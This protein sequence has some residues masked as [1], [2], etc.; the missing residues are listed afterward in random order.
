M[1]VGYY[2]TAPQSACHKGY[3][4]IIQL[5]LDHKAN[6][7]VKG[8]DYGIALVAASC[9][10]QAMKVELLLFKG[11]ADIHAINDCGQTAVHCASWSGNRDVIEQLSSRGANIDTLS[12]DGTACI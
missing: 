9:Q 1:Q 7:N 12:K 2:H 8:G 6:V 5:L 3:R 11:G 10:D 4:R